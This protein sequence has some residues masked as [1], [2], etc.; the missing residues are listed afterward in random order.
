MKEN[1]KD[2]AKDFYDK[3]S[4]NL[5]DTQEIQK[6]SEE[7]D[8]KFGSMF[9]EIDTDKFFAKAQIKS[10][11]SQKLKEQREEI[12]IRIKS[13]KNVVR[14]QTGSFK[15]DSCYDDCLDIVNEYE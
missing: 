4:H 11:I 12:M 7:F 2:N 9:D 14:K 15:Y 3:F 6:W 13:V 1:I 5:S 10:F 8:E